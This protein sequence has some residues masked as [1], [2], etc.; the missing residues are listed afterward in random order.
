MRRALAILLLALAFVAQAGAA[1][2]IKDTT[3]LR[4]ARDAQLVGYGLV[5]GLQ[6]TG[7][8]LRNAPF[9]DQALQSMLERLG[10]AMR[11]SSLRN[12]NVAA[13]IVTADLPYGMD[14]GQ[15]L[16]VTV[17]SL[18][19]STSLMGGTLLLT[20][21]TGPDGLPRASAQG[22]VTVTGF[23][24]VGQAETV[25]QGVPTAG[26]IPNGGIVESPIEGPV[27]EM[28]MFLELRNPDYKTA[29]RILDAINAFSQRVYHKPIAFER[30]ARSVELLRPGNVSTPR[31]MSQIGELMIDP[32]TAARVV[33]DSRTG[34]VV[35]GQD[36]QISTVAVTHGTLNVRITEAPQ[37]SQPAPLSDGKTVVT[38]STQVNVNEA[39]GPVAI[40]AGSSLR[41]LVAGLNRLGV[42]PSGVIAI[43][44]AIKSAGALQADLV[45]Q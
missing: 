44:Q 3:S 19:D 37:V 26:R 23:D 31:L 41:S 35:I 27:D 11:G 38:P 32:D 22:A 34:T 10:L 28:R 2:R 12:K 29:M 30:D 14:A 8:S 9:T 24:A 42:K 20:Q 18:G 40:V 21:L 39:G 4:G 25:S 45:V 43:L 1:V 6:G 15:R 36:V 16:D 7:D 5:I 17:S 13:V 33:V